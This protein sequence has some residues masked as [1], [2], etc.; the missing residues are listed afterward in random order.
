MVHIIGTTKFGIHS[1]G[2]NNVLNH[3]ISKLTKMLPISATKSIEMQSIIIYL[4]FL[5][6]LSY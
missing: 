4:L 1:F 2:F 6:N 3:S 5:K